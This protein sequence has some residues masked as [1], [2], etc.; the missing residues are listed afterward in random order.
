MAE[1]IEIQLQKPPL[2]FDNPVH[3]ITPILFV[4]REA[5]VDFFVNRKA[6]SLHGNDFVCI[7]L[8]QNVCNILQCGFIG[9]LLRWELVEPVGIFLR[10]I[11]NRE[12][13][14]NQKIYV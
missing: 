2:V 12:V 6:K 11:L 13:D 7:L 5:M 1:I 10:A 8:D 14:A 9:I 4:Q 3:A